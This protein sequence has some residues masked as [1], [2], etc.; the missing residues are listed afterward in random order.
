MFVGRGERERN[1]D[2]CAIHPSVATCMPQTRNLAPNQGPGPKLRHMSW[3]G[4]E[5]A[6]SWFTGRC[7]IH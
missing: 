2:V 5:R 1:I 6:T 7:S 3:L 4:M